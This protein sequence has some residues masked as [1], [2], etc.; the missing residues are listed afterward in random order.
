[1]NFR[2]KLAC[3]NAAFPLLSL[4]KALKIIQLLDFAGVDIGLFEGRGNINPS[5]ELINPISSGKRLGK[6]IEESNLELADIFELYCF[7]Y[8]INFVALF[9]VN[10]DIFNSNPSLII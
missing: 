10:P 6:L 9:P 8:Y 4:D 2:T 3:S 5:Q 1:M 7:R